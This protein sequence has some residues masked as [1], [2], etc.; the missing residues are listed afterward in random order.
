MTSLPSEAFST[1]KELQEIVEYRIVDLSPSQYPRTK[2]EHFE[3]YWGL[4]R[5]TLDLS[6]PMNHM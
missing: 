1:T 3:Y 4:Q 2:I 6:L 5:C